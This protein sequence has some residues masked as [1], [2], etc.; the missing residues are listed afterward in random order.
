MLEITNVSKNYG[1]LRAVTGL[2]VEVR[3]GEVLGIIGK[4][5]AGKSTTFKMIL[6]FIQPTTGDVKFNG[7]KLRKEDLNDIGYM[8]EERGLYDEMTIKQEVLYFAS[9]HNFN[10]KKTVSKLAY[11]MEKLDVKGNIEDKV[12]SLSKG[13]QQKVQLIT[14]FIHEPKLLILDEPFSGL[15]PVNTSALIEVILDL[16]KEGTAI[17][18]S[19]HNMNNVEKLSDKILLLVNGI[20]V[21]QGE[22]QK[23]KDGFGKTHLYLE[24]GPDKESFTKMRGVQDI[25]IDHPGYQLVFKNEELARETLKQVQEKYALTGFRLFT[26]SLDEIFKLVT[27]EKKDE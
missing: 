22:S 1:Q 17:I 27:E 26:P 10:K 9:L 7:H 8:P 16:K 20:P 15:D 3:S 12:S 24:N 21:L 4:N 2:N 6:N 5:G 23:I 25:L 14:A 18:F 11:W 13:N 19:S